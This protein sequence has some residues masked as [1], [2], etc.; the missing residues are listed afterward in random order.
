[1]ADRL[2]AAYRSETA[3]LRA[4]TIRDLLRLWPALDWKRLDSTYPAWAL[5][6]GQLVATNRQTSANLAAAYLQA[7][8][9]AAGVAGSAPLTFRGDLDPTQFV[10]ALRVTSVVAAKRAAV[11]GMPEV[12]AMRAAFVQSSGAMSRLVLDGGRDTIVDTVRNDP[13]AAGWQRVTAGSA[14]GF[15]RM[16]AGRGAVYKE[17]TADFASHDHCHCSA[18]PIYGEL[19]TV[20]DYVPTTRSVS[21]VDRARVRKWLADNPQS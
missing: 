13:T 2:T 3:A 4:G 5:A 15:C 11:A 8:R 20:R 6:T 19:R 7:T 21:D 10:T 17:D 14:C 9:Q 1:M 16:L 18:L 12:K